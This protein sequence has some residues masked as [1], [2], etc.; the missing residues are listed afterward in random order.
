MKDGACLKCGC[1]EAPE[2]E[3]GNCRCK[4]EFVEHYF[5]QHK[6][7]CDSEELCFKLKFFKKDDPTFDS[8]K[9]FFKKGALNI[10][11][12]RDANAKEF[13]NILYKDSKG[14]LILRFPSKLNLP[15]SKFLSMGRDRV[16][17]LSNGIA[18]K[19][20]TDIQETS[21]KDEGPDREKTGAA[22]MA[23]KIAGAFLGAFDKSLNGLFVMSSLAGIDPYG[24]II[25]F[26]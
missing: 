13:I 10:I 1:S 26:S 12:L 25:A 7:N 19:T 22:K 2:G 5:K 6:E 14:E 4:E 17:S 11:L 16:I 18:Y 24:L 9:L 8:S 21:F 3:C 15:D 20:T 23:G